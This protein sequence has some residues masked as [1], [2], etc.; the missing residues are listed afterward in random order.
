M[1]FTI[2]KKEIKELFNKSVLITMVFIVLMFG[3]LGNIFDSMNEGMKEKPKVC[4]VLLGTGELTEAMKASFALGAEIL[5]SGGDR[6]EAE[7]ICREKKGV[8]VILADATFDSLIMAEEKGTLDVLWFLEGIGVTNEVK[9][10]LI[11]SLISDAERSITKI[12][13]SK[14][15][16]FHSDHVLSP[17]LLKETTF[18]KNKVVKNSSP[19]LVIKVVQSQTFIAPVIMMM[20][21]IMAGTNVIGSMA[22]E[23]ENKTLETLLTMPIKRSEIVVGKIIGSST[24]GLMTA[25]VYMLGF[26]YYMRSLGMSGLGEIASDLKIM[27]LDFIFVG[28]SFLASILSGLALAMLLGIYS[29]DTK[30]AQAMSMPLTLLVMVPYFISMMMDFELL[31][32]AGR[33]LLF[34]IPFTHPMNVLKFLMFDRYDMVMAGIIYSSA[35]FVFLVYLNVRIFNSD[36]IL[37]AG[38]PKT[39]KKKGILGLLKK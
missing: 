9:T 15:K 4:L 29:N 3:F 18:I 26:S 36:R 32:L 25:A 2:I 39:G 35:L 33:V 30:S 24:V 7:R 12:L 8:A 11:T 16:G 1:I 22:I 28:A 17:I 23:K 5:Y 21:M 27:P 10:T 34:L 6:S 14:G 13:I 20:L 38:V 19:N 31:P 37:T